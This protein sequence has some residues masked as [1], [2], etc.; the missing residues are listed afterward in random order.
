MKK[1]LLT[2]YRSRKRRIEKLK[3]E[4]ED[5]RQ[6][7]VDVVAGKVQSSMREHPYLPQRVSVLME[8]PVEAARIDNQ[9]RKKQSEINQLEELNR[10]VEEFV[11]GIADPTDKS[12][13]EYYYLDGGK[14]VTQN[15]VADKMYLDRSIV[16]RIL[17]KY[18]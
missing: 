3:S 8:E 4:I 6:R 9:I 17:R 1:E 14:K 10:E 13:F 18:V 15:E 5:I 7:D 12:V 16:S 2:Q 11:D